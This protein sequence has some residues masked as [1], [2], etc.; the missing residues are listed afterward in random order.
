MNRQA[1]ISLIIV[2]AVIIIGFVG[3][4]IIVM[5]QK[6]R[7][8]TGTIQEVVLESDKLLAY[9]EGEKKEVNETQIKQ[10]LSNMMADC[11]QMPAFGVALDNE[12]KDAIKSKVWLELEYDKTIVF[13]EMPFDKLLIE[14]GE[15]YTGFNLMRHHDGKYEG[16][17]Y[18][19]DLVEHDMSELYNYLIEL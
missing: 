16:R 11:R 17:C 8:M 19:V 14:V 1:K 9:V 3:G 7:E 2:I 4:G 10:I 12:V 15:D 6:N 5:A 13:D 18:Y